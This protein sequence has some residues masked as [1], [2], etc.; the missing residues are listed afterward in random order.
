MNIILPCH[1]VS[2]GVNITIDTWK[3]QMVQ[4]KTHDEESKGRISAPK[5]LVATVF[6]SHQ[7]EFPEHPTQP[8][9]VEESLHAPIASRAEFNSHSPR[10]CGIFGVGLGF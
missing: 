4:P 2:P 5:D 8:P 9:S 3:E 10:G 6:R 7:L 1:I